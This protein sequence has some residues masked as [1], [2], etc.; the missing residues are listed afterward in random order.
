LGIQFK[1]TAGSDIHAGVSIDQAVAN[2]IGHQTR[3][4]SLELSCDAIR[5]A[6][7]CDSGYSC[8]YQYNISWSSP[9]TPMAAEYNPR[10]VFERLFGAGSPS[11]RSENL[12]R[13]QHEQQ[14]LLDFVMEDARDMQRR[15]DS[16]DKDKLEQYLTGVREIEVRIQKAERLGPAKDP[17]IETPGGVPT[18]YAE[19]VQV[20]FD[21]LALA[22]QTDSTRVATLPA[23]VL[24]IGTAVCL[25]TSGYVHAELYVHGYRTIPGIGPAFLLQASGSIAVALLLLIGA[26]LILRLAAAAL[27]AG[28]LGGFALSRTVGVFGFI[29][30]GLNP[31]PEALI[32]IAV[33]LA[34]LLLL[35][36]PPAIARGGRRSPLRPR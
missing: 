30:R 13:R 10:L 22:F 4:P 23:P 27:T 20:M 9:T 2:Q 26:P 3:F 14:S 35:V 12:K 31:A 33:E 29:E 1:K 17:G 18:G 32:S 21:M 36:I 7:D 24:R 19:Y 5:K 25:A 34:A 11:E 28:A 8:A 15:L 16:R 6:G